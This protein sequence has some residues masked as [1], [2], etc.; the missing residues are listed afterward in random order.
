MPE[1][2]SVH[3][4]RCYCTEK[5]KETS[6]LSG[7]FRDKK[8]VPKGPSKMSW[9]APL[10][11][12][13]S[14]KGPIPK[15]LCPKRPIPSETLWDMRVVFTEPKLDQ[16][17]RWVNREYPHIISRRNQYF[18]LQAIDRPQSWYVGESQL[19]RYCLRC[20]DMNGSRN[21]AVLTIQ[22]SLWK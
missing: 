16:R 19:T 7:P 22:H 17:G 5:I 13:V 12:K 4:L 10:W 15:W 8:S 2:E 18:C 14:R 20:L 6:I 1:C 21:C 9:K 11:W 3:F